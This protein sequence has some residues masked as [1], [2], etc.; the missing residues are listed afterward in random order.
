MVVKPMDWLHDSLVLYARR[1]NWYATRHSIRFMMSYFGGRSVVGCEVGVQHGANSLTLLKNLNIKCLYLV[2]PYVCYEGIDDDG[3]TDHVRNR[4][5]AY[6]RLS[7]FDGHV[8]FIEKFSHDA[9]GD[10]VGPLDF[11]YIDGN[12]RYGFVRSDLLDYGGLVCSGG[13]ICGHDFDIPDVARAVCEYAV[14][15]GFVVYSL[16]HPGDWWMVKV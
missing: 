2:D 3:G 13:V 11:V 1:S 6:R 15:N 10:I 7:S 8:V 16:G 12:H 4:S 5:D 9:V 14:V